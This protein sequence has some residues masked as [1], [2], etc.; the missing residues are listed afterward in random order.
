MMNIC[1]EAKSNSSYKTICILGYCKPELS[2]LLSPMN[3]SF[4]YRISSYERFHQSITKD[5]IYE[6]AALY[7]VNLLAELATE[8]IV[9]VSLFPGG[10]QIKFKL[11][12]ANGNAA[13][14]KP[15]RYL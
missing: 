6:E 10:S 11:L 15:K 4:L 13:I 8:E 9:K 1:G 2:S 14:G 5:A 12:F 7:V 3:K